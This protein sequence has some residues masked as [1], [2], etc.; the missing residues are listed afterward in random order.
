VAQGDTTYVLEVP[1]AV[2]LPNGAGQVVVR[3]EQGAHQ[4]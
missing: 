1:F 2:A 3:I 4:I